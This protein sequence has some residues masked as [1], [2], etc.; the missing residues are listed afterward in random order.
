MKK[1]NNKK[2]L[3]SNLLQKNYNCKPCMD[4]YPQIYMRLDGERFL[5]KSSRKGA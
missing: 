2:K 4:L 5:N 1:Y 3:F